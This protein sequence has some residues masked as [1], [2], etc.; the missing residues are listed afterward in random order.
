[1]KPTLVTLALSCLAGSVLAA[2]AQEMAS[3][4]GVD[5]AKFAG[6]EGMGTPRQGDFIDCAAY[7]FDNVVDGTL[8][9]IPG[10]D[11]ILPDPGEER[12]CL[13]FQHMFKKKKEERGDDSDIV[14]RGFWPFSGKGSWKSGARK[15]PFGLGKDG[16]DLD[17]LKA[18]SYGMKLEK[19]L[20]SGQKVDLEKELEREFGNGSD[21][22]KAANR[23]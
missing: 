4:A 9:K 1:M 11:K 23:G 10:M 22:E 17:L 21:V 8:R 6:S 19:K 16:K 20:K 15:N 14:A 18:I 2:P 12:L 7:V 5:S 13:R 3:Q